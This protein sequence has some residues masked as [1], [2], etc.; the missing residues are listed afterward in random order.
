M[1]QSGGESSAWP[2]SQAAGRIYVATL[3]FLLTHALVCDGQ[4]KAKQ[5]IV[6]GCNQGDALP[7]IFCILA[8]RK[9][10]ILLNVHLG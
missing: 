4:N 8:K 1:E 5:Q 2:D 7:E 10:A 9:Q 6:V 3:N